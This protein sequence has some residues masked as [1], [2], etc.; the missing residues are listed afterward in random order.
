MFARKWYHS[1]SADLSIRRLK[2]RKIETIT[3][4]SVGHLRLAIEDGKVHNAHV[5]AQQLRD[6][7]DDWCFVAANHTETVYADDQL[8]SGVTPTDLNRLGHLDKEF[9]LL[10]EDVAGASSQDPQRPREFVL[11]SR[12]DV[13]AVLAY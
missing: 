6:M 1:F 10:I 8:I 7:P 11:A 5:L 13:S 12:L 2:L 9:Y 3:I 4:W